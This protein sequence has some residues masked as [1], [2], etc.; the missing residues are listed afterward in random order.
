ML[1]KVSIEYQRM[2]QLTNAVTELKGLREE[3]IEVRK[4]VKEL[5]EKKAD[6]EMRMRKKMAGGGKSE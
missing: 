5:K 6:V 4:Q 2:S 3:T 1:L